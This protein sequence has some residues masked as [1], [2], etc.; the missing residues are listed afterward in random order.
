MRLVASNVI[1]HEMIMYTH[2]EYICALTNADMHGAQGF[3][4]MVVYSHARVHVSQF[5]R[6]HG[7]QEFLDT[8][9]FQRYAGLQRHI[10]THTHTRCTRCPRYSVM[11]RH[12][13]HNKHT[14]T[15][16]YTHA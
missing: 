14:H 11:Q 1:Y 3:I 8:L 10:Y 2:T 7:A 5:T 6:M 15:Y 12:A 13:D 4:K 9:V 16:T